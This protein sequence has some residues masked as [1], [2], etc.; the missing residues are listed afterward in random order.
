MGAQ[1]PLSGDGSLR[2]WR[3]NVPHGAA[4]PGR[5]GVPTDDAPHSQVAVRPA[6]CADVPDLTALYRTTVAFQEALGA[7]EPA[8]IPDA[9]AA[10]EL[11]RGEVASMGEAGTLLVA[12]TTEGIRGLARVRLLDAE[13]GDGG[14]QARLEVTTCGG[15][16][17][18]TVARLLVQRAGT[19]AADRGAGTLVLECHPANEAA[20]DFYT[21]AC[22]FEASAVVLSQPLPSGT[23]SADLTGP[24]GAVGSPP[25][26]RAR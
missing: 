8:R 26:L 25:P 24:Q 3:V 16:C 7:M 21:R 2:H 10:A 13:E 14:P 1:Q 9:S 4:D 18:E 11:V 6:T 12:E 23:G 22:G 20:V 5:D 19:W 17:A 15:R